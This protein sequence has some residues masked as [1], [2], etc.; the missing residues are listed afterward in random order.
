M[1]APAGTFGFHTVEPARPAATGYGLDRL[2][3]AR[4]LISRARYGPTD[5]ERG[6]TE[7]ID[8]RKVRLNQLLIRVGAKIVYTYDFGDGWEHGIVL[9]KGLPIEPNMAYPLCTGGRGACP[10]E[11][12]G[13]LGGFYNLLEALQNPRHPQHEELLE[14]VGEDYDPEKFSIEAINRILHGRKKRAA[15]SSG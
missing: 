13:G 15:R 6:V 9:E 4:V 7:A 2:S 3:P 12:C 14:W 8:E 11:D 5:P 1:A 10:P